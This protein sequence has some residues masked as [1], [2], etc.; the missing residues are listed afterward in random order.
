MILATLAEFS[1]VPTTWNDT[2]HLTHR[3]LFLLV[4]LALMGDPTFYIAIVANQPG[5]SGSLALILGIAQF[6]ISSVRPC[7]SESC[8]PAGCLATGL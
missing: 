3:S 6:F 8:H 4:T 2:S 5:G 1:Y 7:C